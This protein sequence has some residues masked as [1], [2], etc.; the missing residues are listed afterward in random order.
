MVQNKMPT[1][2]KVFGIAILILVGMILWS[3]GGSDDSRLTPAGSYA[4]LTTREFQQIV[5]DPD[6]HRGE[7]ILVFGKI[8]QFDS[9]TGSDTFRANTGAT[10]AEANQNTFLIG[11]KATLA[12]M[13]EGDSFAANVTI[14]GTRSYKTQIGGSMTVP[15]F[16]IDV[17]SK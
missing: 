9:A 11:D 12:N 2:T 17:I 15:V 4:K 3:C 10:S 7:G 14:V 8:T 13:V 6:A 16:Q 1:K 5:K